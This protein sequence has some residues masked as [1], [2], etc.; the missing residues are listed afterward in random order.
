MEKEVGIIYLI[1]PA[2]L[3][4][5]QRFKIGCSSKNTLDR[6]KSYRK[7]TRYLYICE[8]ENPF[9]L[10]KIIKESFNNKFILIAGREFFEGN[11]QE[12]CKLFSE[13][14]CENKNHLLIQK[15]NEC[16]T[17]ND[18]IILD[19]AEEH[20]DDTESSS[21]FH[22]EEKDFVDEDILDKGINYKEDE[23]FGGSKKIVWFDIS[24]IE[25]DIWET[26]LE[27]NQYLIDIH[28]IITRGPDNKIIT[29]DA[30]SIDT[31]YNLN[32]ENQRTETYID[33]NNA[34]YIDNLIKKKFI[35]NGRIY[36]LN[37]K[38]FI[39]SLDKLKTKIN[40]CI[41]H[42]SLLK[43]L[44]LYKNEKF[45][46][47]KYNLIQRH[48]NND[49][50]I[51][52]YIYCDLH[53]KEDRIRGGKHIYLDTLREH[54]FLYKF[55]NIWYSNEY[56]QNN[57]P[58]LIE[59][60]SD[61]NAYLINRQYIYIELNTKTN[62]KKWSNVKR[63]YLYNDGNCPWLNKNNENEYKAKMAMIKSRNYHI[64]NNFLDV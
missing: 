23:E 31:R 32:C 61:D 45:Q 41:L 39:K 58:Y 28:Y 20:S 57:L 52:G 25:H 62:P 13:I 10:E 48:I 34:L 7:G 54:L 8:C 64:L 22:L 60:N 51:N 43:A 5:T 9:K 56:L 1:Q 17:S 46:N 63:E 53:S 38:K 55:N 12:M 26:P 59:I 3:V 49:T 50:I 2:E 4:G 30:I 36:D 21:S 42:S 24:T 14:L 33:N 11:E 29:H 19:V 6:I 27:H 16:N 15:K 35:E 18:D 44:S 37:N 47:D 40:N